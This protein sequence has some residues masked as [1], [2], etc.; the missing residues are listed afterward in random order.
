MRDEHERKHRELLDAMCK[1]AMKW[2]QRLTEYEISASTDE[3][4]ALFVALTMIIH[5]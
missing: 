1:S 5:I 2:D 3:K 4:T